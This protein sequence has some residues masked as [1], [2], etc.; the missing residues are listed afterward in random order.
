MSINEPWFYAV[1]IPELRVERRRNL[2][3][4]QYFSLNSTFSENNLYRSYAFD[5]DPET[6]VFKNRRVLAYVDCG[7]PDGVQLDTNGNVYAGTGDGVQVRTSAPYLPT[8]TLFHL[9]LFTSLL[10]TLLPP[11]FTFAFLV[12]LPKR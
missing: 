6:H 1:R 8:H 4:C 12:N 3:R 5:V 9:V 10:S 7:V 11:P 2:L